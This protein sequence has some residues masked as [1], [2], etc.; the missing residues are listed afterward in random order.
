MLRR[1]AVY[2]SH[3]SMNTR[4]LQL[5]TGIIFSLLGT[6]AFCDTHLECDYSKLEKSLITSFALSESQ[7]HAYR[8]SVES[9]AV[10]SQQLGVNFPDVNSVYT[11]DLSEVKKDAMSRYGIL[12]SEAD[13]LVATIKLLRLNKTRFDIEVQDKA[14]L[15]LIRVATN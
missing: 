12:E 1:V 4:K 13:Y 2:V 3:R 14:C 7:A 11:S 10:Q 6:H 15:G 8:L 5:V 9:F